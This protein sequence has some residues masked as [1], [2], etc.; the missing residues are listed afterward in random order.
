[1]K[2]YHNIIPLQPSS[3]RL[4]HPLFKS[5]HV[6]EQKKVVCQT[7]GNTTPF[8]FI[9]N[10]YI[11]ACE[12]C[13]AVQLK[14]GL[15]CQCCLG[16]GRHAHP[17]L[18]LWLLNDNTTRWLGGS[19][20]YYISRTSRSLL[21]NTLPLLGSSGLGRRLGGGGE[22]FDLGPEVVA[23]AQSALHRAQNDQWS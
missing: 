10:P 3:H 7:L 8:T 14:L 5:V 19:P 4:L 2:D 21:S 1:M 6:L 13:L 22:A 16:R 18:S 12:E 11:S 20:G 23:V 15:P 9:P 17:D